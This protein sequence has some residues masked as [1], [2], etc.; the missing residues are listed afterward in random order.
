M[1]SLDFTTT[2]I[3]KIIADNKDRVLLFMFDNDEFKY[4]LE[5]GENPTDSMFQ[6]IGGTECIVI[7][8]YLYSKR[9]GASGGISKKDIPITSYKPISTIQGVLVLDKADDYKYLDK[10]RIYVQ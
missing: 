5:P 8:D 9:G 2:A 4:F 10:S 7:K 3:K 1:A 6:E